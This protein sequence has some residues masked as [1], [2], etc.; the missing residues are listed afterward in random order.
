[1][2]HV[3]NSDEYFMIMLVNDM[4]QKV[5]KTIRLPTIIDNSS[6]DTQSL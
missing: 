1:M 6:S 3:C 5:S 2:E 4:H